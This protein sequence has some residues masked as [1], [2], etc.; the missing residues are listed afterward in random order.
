MRKRFEAQLT[1]G[2]T[3]IE[4]IAIPT[5]AGMNFQPFYERC[6]TF[7]QMMNLVNA[8]SVY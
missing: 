2:S 1:I 3:P 4:K 6:N 7:T 5:K 8:Y